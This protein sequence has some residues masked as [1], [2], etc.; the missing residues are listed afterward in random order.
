MLVNVPD[1]MAAR[2]VELLAPLAILRVA[3]TQQAIERLAAVRPLLTCALQDPDAARTALLR[4][5][6]LDVGA[7]FLSI[8]VGCGPQELERLLKQALVDA[9]AV[10]P[11]P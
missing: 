1:D 5:R 8:P 10:D 6:A 3:D 9:E 7:G 4:G 2:C 11:T